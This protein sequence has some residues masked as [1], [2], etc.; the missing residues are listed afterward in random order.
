MRLSVNFSFSYLSSDFK[1]SIAE[2]NLES[3]VATNAAV[4]LADSADCLLLS[5]V[6][7]ASKPPVCLQI[8]G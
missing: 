2:S 3:I 8:S 1:F 5:A 4:C 6:H 7:F